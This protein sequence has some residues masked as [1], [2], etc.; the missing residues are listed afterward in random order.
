M[1]LST[2]GLLVVTLSCRGVGL[3]ASYCSFTALLPVVRRYLLS[4]TITTTLLC[5]VQTPAGQV[6]SPRIDLQ[7]S[8]IQVLSCPVTL[9][10]WVGCATCLRSINTLFWGMRVRSDNGPYDVLFILPAKGASWAERWDKHPT[11]GTARSAPGALHG[12]WFAFLIRHRVECIA[13]P[14]GN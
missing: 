2:L 3:P 8:T 11:V 6:L 1:H 5:V 4:K 12:R 7:G 9:L 10:S 14:L 13:G